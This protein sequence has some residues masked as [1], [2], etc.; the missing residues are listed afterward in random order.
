MGGNQGAQGWQDEDPLDDTTSHAPVIPPETLQG[1]AAVVGG[2][3][4]PNQ[5]EEV[6]PVAAEQQERSEAQPSTISTSVPPQYVD[7]R[8]L[9][10]IVKAMMKGMA[11]SATQT[12]P[13]MQIPQ[14]APAT[15]TTTD[16]VVLLVQLVK[17][18]REMGCEPYMGEQDAEMARRWIRK[19]E[20]TMIQIRIPKDL[21]V[22]CATQLLS[23]RAMTWWETVQLRRATETLTWRD[24][25]TEFENQFYSRYHRKVKEQEFL[26]LRQGDMSVLEYER[27]FH[28]L[29]LFAP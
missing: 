28:D 15:G 3:R 23:D 4:R 5:I 16:N 9:I 22:N 8:L 25:K 11:G 13:A 6:P 19:V 1:E 21:K 27:R 14:A 26:A 7:A 29:S 18:M 24:S 20:K 12:T 10:H 17:S 2:G